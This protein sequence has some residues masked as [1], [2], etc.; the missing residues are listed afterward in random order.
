[1]AKRLWCIRDAQ[2]Y[3]N[4]RDVHASLLCLR[5]DVH[6]QSAEWTHGNLTFCSSTLHVT[7]TLSPKGRLIRRI[8]PGSTQ[9]V[10]DQ[11]GY[12]HLQRFYSASMPSSRVSSLAAVCLCSAAFRLRVTPASE[13]RACQRHALRFVTLGT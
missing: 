11:E 8:V 9:T 6:T 4:K 3:Q 1:M 10:A 12:T 13:S 5:H 2:G 7:A